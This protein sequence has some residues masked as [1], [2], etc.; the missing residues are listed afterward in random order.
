MG[1][2]CTDDIEQE[3]DRMRAEIR[4]KAAHEQWLNEARAFHIG[5]GSQ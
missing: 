3:L 5:Q 4:L 1:L 2:G